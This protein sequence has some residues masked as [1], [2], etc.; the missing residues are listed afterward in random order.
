V[1]NVHEAVAARQLY[2]DLLKRALTHTLYWPLD[3]QWDKSAE[4]VPEE[5]V[6]AVREAHERGETDPWQI[7]REGR[8]WP[9]FAQTM[10]GIHRLDNVQQCVET[11]LDEDVPGDLIEAGVWRGGVAILMRAVLAAHD[12]NDRKVFAADSFQGLPSPNVADYPADAGDRHH[13][14]AQL[15]VT[16]ADVERNFELYG[17]LDEQ[18]VFVEGW[19]SASLP[20]LRGRPWSVVRIDGDMYESTRDALVNLYPD[21]AIGGFLIIDDLA[22]DACR[23]AVDDYRTQYGIREPIEKVDWTGAYWRKAR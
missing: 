10:V 7:R 2:L 8:D 19:F 12:V 4:F 16:R 18:V 21:L 20:T 15:A 5:F 14:A 22:H 9:K 1:G 13:T 3:R 17:L 6:R 11:V 23:A